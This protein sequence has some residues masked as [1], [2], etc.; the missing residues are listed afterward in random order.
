MDTLQALLNK[1]VELLP[2]PPEISK[3]VR[4]QLFDDI[5]KLGSDLLSD[6]TAKTAKK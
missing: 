3:D 6:L 2:W 5:E 1:I 4:Q